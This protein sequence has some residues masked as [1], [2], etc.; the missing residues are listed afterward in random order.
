MLETKIIIISGFLGAGK[1]TFL[2]KYIPY[3]KGKVVVVENEFGDVSI[4]SKLIN[5]DVPIKEIYSGCVCCSLKGE[6]KGGILNL[7]YEYRPDYILIEPSGVGKLSEVMKAC[8]EIEDTMPSVKL[9]ERITLVEAPA[10]KEYLEDFGSFFTDQI[11]WASHIFLSMTKNLSD[12]E[13]K[14]LVK[15]I[16]EENSKS[17]IYTEDFRKLSKE[18]FEEIFNVL[19]DD[20]LDEEGKK[21]LENYFVENKTFKSYVFKDLIF[22]SLTEIEDKINKLLK[23]NTR[24]TKTSGHILRI[25]GVVKTKD[26]KEYFVSTTRHNLNIKERSKEE[27]NLNND[28][29]IIG[30]SLDKEKIRRALNFKKLSM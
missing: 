4:D 22:D 12:E 7:I 26:N 20:F 19:E 9:K 16:R 25:K 18:D 6:L 28:L 27:E 5:E 15:L 3:L 8:Y 21:E 2:N 11:Y 10:Y 13:I 14:D 30:S 17:L 24:L 29:I 23:E 1:T